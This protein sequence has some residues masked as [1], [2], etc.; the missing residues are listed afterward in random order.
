MAKPLTAAQRQR[1]IDKLSRIRIELSA[2]AS[3]T[4]LTSSERMALARAADALR[5]AIELMVDEAARVAA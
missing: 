5:V 4:G 3:N 2:D 1:K